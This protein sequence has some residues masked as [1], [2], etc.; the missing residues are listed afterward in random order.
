MKGKKETIAILIATA[1]IIAAVHFYTLLY[2]PASGTGKA[3]AVEIPRG[4]SFRVVVNTLA[5]AGLLKYSEGF[6]LAAMAKG[7]HKKI[8]AGEYEL[9][10]SMTPMEMLD[11]LM[12]GRTK[13]YSLTV[14]EGYSVTDIAGAVERNG[15]AKKEEFLAQVN[16][17]RFVSSLGLPGPTLEGYLFPD[18]Y[19]V[20][21]AAAPEDIADII[22]RMTGRFKEV[23][24]EEFRAL[25]E[26]KGMT[27]RE[28]ITLASIIEKET[29]RQEEMQS[30]SAVFHNRLKKRI[31]LQSDPTVIYA[32]ANFDGNLTKKH[33]LARTPYNTYIK[34]GLPPGP[35]AN[36]GRA[37]I[38][39]ALNPADE[40]Y[41][42][43][44]SRND[45][46][47]YFSKTLAEHNDAVRV[48]QKS[49]FAARPR[50]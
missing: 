48:Y 2:T 18:T 32:I 25:A 10:P 15:I 29:G 14:P 19:A 8:Q 4:A 21:K 26:K 43:F 27:D 23:Y 20:A 11:I 38:Y 3:V 17:R 34:N 37:A 42:Y 47:H 36:P 39:A 1:V 24:G 44:V 7:A 22:K 16:D 35:I 41:L 13:H 30:V 40:K 49:V 9:S 31:P 45:G 6:S 12:A 50:S 33:L 5:N 46:T 28:V